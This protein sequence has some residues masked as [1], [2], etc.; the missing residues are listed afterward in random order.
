MTCLDFARDDE[1]VDYSGYSKIVENEKQTL[2][3]GIR[4]TDTWRYRP[5]ERG[6][7]MCL[8]TREE[9]DFSRVNDDFCDCVVDGSDE[10]GTS[11]CQNGRFYC[12]TQNTGFPGT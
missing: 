2:L 11:A 10:P 6:N 5:N 8:H 4:P 7:F 9:L 1:L 12:D 3:K